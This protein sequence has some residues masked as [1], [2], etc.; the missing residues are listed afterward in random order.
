V[1]RCRRQAPVPETLLFPTPRLSRAN[2][3]G[4]RPYDSSSSRYW[5]EVWMKGITVLVDEH[6]H[7]FDRSR[8]FPYAFRHTYAQL[9]AD[10]GVPL[11]V[12]QA[13]MAHLEP[14][15]TQVYYRVAR[16]RRAEAV[17]AIA[18]K[19][20]FDVTGGRLRPLGPGDDVAARTRAGVGS[21]P[22]PR[23]HLPRD[24]QGVRVGTDQGTGVAVRS[25]DSV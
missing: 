19:Y 4:E 13:L 22:V 21:V 5:L 10:A 23:R 12:L 3:L 18:A 17:R 15:T 9:R 6:G 11:E 25:F 24:E 20:Q 1:V 14:S 8:V 2:G 7:S 16:T